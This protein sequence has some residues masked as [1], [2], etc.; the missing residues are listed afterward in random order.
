MVDM[1]QRWRLAMRVGAGLILAAGGVVLAW[2]PE[3]APG[4]VL[5]GLVTAAWPLGV[6]W[7]AARGTALRATVVWAALAV[8]LGVMAQGVGLGE[9]LAGG[10]PGAGHWAYLSALA[11]L[12]ALISV[13]N[14]RRP[15]GG[16]W[17]LL[18]GLLVLIFLI[19][20]LEG[21]GLARG[22]GAWERLR[23]EAPWS[24]FFWVLMLAGVINYLPTRYS[25]AA[26]WLALG[27]GLE[28]LALV[29]PYW[30][31]AWRGTTWSAF[32]WALAGTLWAAELCAHRGEPGRS[33][34]ER[35]WFPFRDHWGMIW[36]VRVRERFNRS[37]EAAGWPIR[38]TWHGVV[39]AP[40]AG[41]LAVD[42]PAAAEATLKGQLRRFAT[43]ARIDS[44]GGGISPQ[45]TPRPQRGRP[46]TTGKD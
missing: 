35:L 16:A 8:V 23:L 44:W 2:D 15:G 25:L 24:W 34:L 9:P 20:W 21:S 38:L 14:A 32:P 26:D 40:D 18:M 33:W 6:A 22:V 7:R 29:W 28:A 10:R 39:P 1:M 19:P 43:E 12:A 27:L 41:G 31:L 45:R 4:W 11:T 42:P 46:R 13:F 5:G 30:P 17:A 37:A 3:R 36:G